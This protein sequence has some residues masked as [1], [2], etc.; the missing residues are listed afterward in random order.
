MAI[1]KSLFQ[2][3]VVKNAR[4]PYVITFQGIGATKH[5]T[6]SEALKKLSS[7]RKKEKVLLKK[8][9]NSVN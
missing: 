4:F 5:L 8:L 2:L 3:K 6:R 1:R 7:I 9:V